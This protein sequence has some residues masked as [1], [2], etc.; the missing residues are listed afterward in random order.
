M[1]VHLERRDDTLKV[2]LLAPF[3]KRYQ[4]RLQVSKQPE[5]LR[6]VLL[7]TLQTDDGKMVFVKNSK[8]G[9]TTIA[10]ILFHYSKGRHHGGRI[11]SERDDF[12]QGL[13]YWKENLEALR[14]KTNTKFTFVRN[15][16]SRAI[17]AFTNFFVD[18]TNRAAP[19]HLKLIGGFGFSDENDVSRNFDVYLDYLQ[20]CFEENAMRTDRH[21]RLQ[22]I[23]IGLGV[24]DYDLIGRLENFEHDLR[25]V[26]EMAGA[27]EYMD[28]HADFR[29]DN[30]SSKNKLQLTKLQ[31]SKI[32]ALYAP[33]Y[34]AFNYN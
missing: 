23:N 15:P 7:T 13:E 29:R 33:D 14:S 3:I 10:N 17:S 20:A 30:R 4:P 11:H 18:K 25:K 6:P 9:C 1:K 16:Q 22:K 5:S 19:N 26:F 27:S 34:E 24:I 2:K 31:Q 12:R 21:F 28:K 8:A 32:E